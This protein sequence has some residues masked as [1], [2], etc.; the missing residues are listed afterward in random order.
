MT[1]QSSLAETAAGGT[2]GSSS[3]D[4]TI[5][6]LGLGMAGRTAAGA[7]GVYVAP[8][9]GLRT[10]VSLT[11]CGFFRANACKDGPSRVFSE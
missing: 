8:L 5:F 9:A 4:A 2:C 7:V 10:A 11:I 3:A 6:V 1:F